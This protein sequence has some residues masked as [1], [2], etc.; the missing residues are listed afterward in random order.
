M[1]FLTVVNTVLHSML[2]SQDSVHFIMNS[3][4]FSSEGSS[5]PVPR[6]EAVISRI[7][8]PIAQPVSNTSLQHVQAYPTATIDTSTNENVDQYHHQLTNDM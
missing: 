2:Y 4:I 6:A 7:S 3:S 5:S 8:E 1:N